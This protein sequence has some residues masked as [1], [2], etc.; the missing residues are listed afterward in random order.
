LDRKSH[1]DLQEQ[2]VPAW[3]MMDNEA[4]A[5][6]RVSAEQRASETLADAELGPAH[7]HVDFGARVPVFEFDAVFEAVAAASLPRH[8]DPVEDVAIALPSRHDDRESDRALHADRWRRAQARMAR[9]RFYSYCL[10][11][12]ASVFALMTFMYGV[13]GRADADRTF[14]GLGVMFAATTAFLLWAAVRVTRP[15][16]LD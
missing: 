13:Q 15:H 4:E 5:E 7:A 3:S 11:L 14:I 1:Y 8:L 12:S 9:Q 6:R 10:T 2:L 16:P